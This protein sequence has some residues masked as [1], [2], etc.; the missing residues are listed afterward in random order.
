VK[1][2]FLVI[3]LLGLLCTSFLPVVMKAV[4]GTWF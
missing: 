2:L 4:N 1:F 3:F